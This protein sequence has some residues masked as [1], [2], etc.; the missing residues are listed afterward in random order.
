M[1]VEVTEQRW[2]QQIIL[3]RSLA[4]KEGRASDTKRTGQGE[5]CLEGT[6]MVAHTT[7]RIYLMKPESGEGMR[8]RGQEHGGPAALRWEKTTV[9]CSEPSGKRMKNLEVMRKK[10]EGIPI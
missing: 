10:A 6:D 9:S 1:K 4:T 3:H 7:E 5:N 8:G 2:W